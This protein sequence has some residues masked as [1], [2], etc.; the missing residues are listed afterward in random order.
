MITLCL[1]L[2]EL[3][4]RTTV[5]LTVFPMALDSGKEKFG[6][7]LDSARPHLLSRRLDPV[8]LHVVSD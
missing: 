1:Q 6:I 5:Q 8:R 3:Y 2:Y 4:M 7:P